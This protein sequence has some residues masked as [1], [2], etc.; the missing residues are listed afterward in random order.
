MIM[1][2]T[3]VHPEV[4]ERR[5]ASK[6]IGYTRL[7]SAGARGHTPRGRITEGSLGG[8][9]AVFWAIFSGE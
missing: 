7:L 5:F 4:C 8:H 1:I 9:A 2:K 3:Q 6:T